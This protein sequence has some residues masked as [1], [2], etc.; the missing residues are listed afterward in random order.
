MDPKRLTG[1]NAGSIKYDLITALCVAGLAGNPVLQTSMTRLIALIT[2]RYN[3][4]RDEVTVGQRDLARMWSVDER[5]VKR[6]MKRLVEAHVLQKIR[7][8]VRGRVTAYRLNYR[9]IFRL[10]Q[11]S[12]SNVG[13]DFEER[14]AA[15]GPAAEV[16]VVKVDFVAK[17]LNHRQQQTACGDTGTQPDKTPDDR[18]RWRQVRAQLR[19][20][21][22]GMFRNWFEK[23]VFEEFCDGC[24][25]L[26]AQSRF[27]ARYIETHLDRQL[28]AAASAAFPA[29]KSL[30][31][32]TG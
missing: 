14:M 11:P 7:P 22:P 23:L 27:V 8:G 2:A 25:V 5:T 1:P 32:K 28:L 16:R 18:G 19:L 24:L 9:E 15:A 29:T 31:I 30:H 21:D 26:Q 6:Q 3:W 10:S 4:A 13:P 12:W 20:A 17:A